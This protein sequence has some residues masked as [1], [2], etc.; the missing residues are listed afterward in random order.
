MYR[1]T[2]T[3]WGCCE[4]F[5]HKDFHKGATELP[6][7]QSLLGFA[8]SEYPAAEAL[9][10]TPEID[11]WLRKMGPSFTWRFMGLWSLMGVWGL[12]FRIWRCTRLGLHVTNKLQEP[13]RRVSGYPLLHAVH[14]VLELREFGF[15]PAVI[16]LCLAFGHGDV[17]NLSPLRASVAMHRSRPLTKRLQ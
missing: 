16:I 8:I 15:N 10:R 3:R 14:E 7:P 9:R 1:Y 2:W 5:F 4:A 17:A 13:P 6:L 11:A 12:G